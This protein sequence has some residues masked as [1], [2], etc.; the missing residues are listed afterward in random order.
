[1]KNTQKK[2]VRAI[3]KSHWL[4]HTEPRLKHLKILKIEDLHNLQCSSLIYNMIN[5]HCPDIFNYAQ[6]Q[7]SSNEHQLRSSQNQPTNLRLPA[8][9]I[10]QAK[11]NFQSFAPQQWNDTPQNIKSAENRRIFKGMLRS[12][13]LESYNSQVACNNPICLDQRYHEP[14]SNS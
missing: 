14:L 12:H 2:S 1:M 9:N 6:N 7:L 5:G 8:I 11:N 4:S 13:I 10:H 3:C